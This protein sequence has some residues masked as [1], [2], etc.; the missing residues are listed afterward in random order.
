MTFRKGDTSV[1]MQQPAARKLLWALILVFC[2][3]LLTVTWRGLELLRHQ[4]EQLRTAAA[5]QAT[6]NLALT[7]AEHSGRTFAEVD[8]LLG[9]LAQSYLAGGSVDELNILSLGMQNSQKNL[10]NLVGVLNAEGH[11]IA[12]GQRPFNPVYSG[13][14]D[15]FV[16]H[17]D[18]PESDGL[19]ISDPLLGRAT[20]LWYIPLTRRIEDSQGRFQGVVIASVNPAY[21]LSLYQSLDMGKKN[22]IALTKSDGTILTGQVSQQ[23]LPFSILFSKAA[24]I[25]AQHTRADGPFDCL[26]APDY[27]DILRLT[28]IA[29]VEGHDIYMMVGVSQ[30][31][32][33]APAL[34]SYR[35]QRRYAVVFTLLILAFLGAL[36]LTD[37]RRSRAEKLLRRYAIV[38]SLTGV[39]N[40]NY[41]EDYLQRHPRD[42]QG[43][44]AVVVADID[45]L[46][47][48]NDTLGHQAGDDLLIRAARLLEVSFAPP[49][50]VCRIGGDEF[51]VITSQEPEYTAQRCQLL[52]ESMA[53][54][55][56]QSTGITLSISVGFATG[57]RPLSELY[58]EA[59]NHMYREKLHRQGSNRSKIIQTMMRLL[60]AKDNITEEHAGRMVEY[61]IGRASCRERVFLTV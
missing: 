34:H 26:W 29:P 27:D 47:L 60:A 53:D 54:D 58:K 61:E 19:L 30:A 4:E 11:L 15:W 22:I 43:H 24:K 25:I 39:F 8:H 23:E 52:R 51:A 10:F 28:T 33:L 38:D 42:S 18:H 56:L 14:R 20:N 3:V 2:L 57:R 13:D 45:G 9:F 37:I 44:Y 41:F 46:K 6:G 16:Y 32:T 50:V 17:R 48:I 59:D 40:R 12:S 31:E 7:L 5:Y 1:E 36:G 35:Y 21:F 55:H 49:A